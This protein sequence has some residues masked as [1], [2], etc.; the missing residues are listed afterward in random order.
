MIT[1]RIR[2][3]LALL[4]AL[5]ATCSAGQLLPSF[6]LLAAFFL[7]RSLLSRLV[8]R[9]CRFAASS[10]EYD[11]DARM[12]IMDVINATIFFIWSTSFLV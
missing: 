12:K 5:A 1:C 6:R 10:A 7:S 4:P 2:L 11:A 3:R 8:L 9:S